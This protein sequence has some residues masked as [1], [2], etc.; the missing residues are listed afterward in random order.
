MGR[1]TGI[2]VAILVADGF[3]QVEY[4]EPK[5]ALENEGAKTV[6]VS[7]GEG[8]LQGVN[9]GEK[10]DRFPID[11]NL[12]D[13]DEASF[14]ALLLPGG[15]LSPDAL[16]ADEKVQEFV[17]GFF[18]SEK[19]VFAICHGPQVLISAKLVKGRRITSFHTVRIDLENAGADWVDAPVVVDGNLI[20]SRGPD[21]LYAFNEKIVETLSATAV[22]QNR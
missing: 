22:S 4:V 10:R 2:T 3:E 12:K 17:R 11:R 18:E 1:L 14:D 13:A 20:S 9:H 7:P 8:E 19:P 6:T 5:K 21:D 16:R 15:V